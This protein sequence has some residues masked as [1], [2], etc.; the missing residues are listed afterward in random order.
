MMT[1]FAVLSSGFFTV[2]AYHGLPRGVRMLS[3]FRA[4]NQGFCRRF[5]LLQKQWLTCIINQ[6]QNEDEN[7][8]IKVR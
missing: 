8:N 7:S 5:S 6:D 2:L 4:R 3:R 1:R